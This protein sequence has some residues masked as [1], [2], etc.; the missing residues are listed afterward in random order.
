MTDRL[1]DSH[2]HIFRRGM[3]AGTG[4]A[5]L[6][7]DSEVDAY[8]ALRR[9]YNI[10][11]GLVVG[12]DADGI[13]PGNS[14]HILSLAQTRPWMATLAYVEPDPVPDPKAI[15]RLLE[16]G[17]RGLAL[18]ATDPTRAAALAK[19]P[20]SVWDVLNRRRAIIS[21]NARP[22][23]MDELVT[24]VRHQ[25][26]AYFLFSHI[27]LPG[28]YS[29]TPSP[30]EARNRLAMLLAL[31][32]SPNVLVKISG[33]YAISDP[34]YAYP[35]KAAHPFIDLVLERFGPARCV[36]GSDFSPAL[37]HVSFPQ[38]VDIPWLDH[39]G[40]SERAAVMGE[41]LLKLLDDTKRG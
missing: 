37:E 30:D 33:L 27:G 3:P 19:W 1:A 34:S 18:Y 4:R 17:H 40:S 12:Y 5:V 24:I 8:E 26:G 32:E 23:A 20:D 10:A 13:D 31:A 11:S 16:D 35:H 36:W 22:P 21:F 41:N 9:K 38:T 15:D 6:G 39:L 25:P 7:N 29:A 2:L 28:G 14:A